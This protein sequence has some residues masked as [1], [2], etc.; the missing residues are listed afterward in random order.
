MSDE[1]E[2]REAQ[3]V[4]V[5]LETRWN[6]ER[7][8]TPALMHELEKAEKR[9]IELFMDGWA[10]RPVMASAWSHYRRILLHSCGGKKKTDNRRSSVPRLSEEF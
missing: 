7:Q 5:E 10:P 9:L 4:F 6:D 2:M 8:R 3:L 1:I